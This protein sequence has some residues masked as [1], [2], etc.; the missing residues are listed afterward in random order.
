MIRLL[1]LA[2]YIPGKGQQYALQVLR[3]IRNQ[4]LAVELKFVGGDMGRAANKSYLRKLQAQARSLN[5]H[6][7]TEFAG[8]TGEVMQEMRDAHII[9]NFSASESFSMVCLEALASAKPLVATRCGG[10]QEIIRHQ[11]NGLLVANGDVHEMTSA[12]ADLVKNP[13]LRTKFSIN[14]QVDFQEKF[15]LQILAE[16]LAQIYQKAWD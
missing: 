4:N 2:N 15:N 13:S 12:V 1:Y 11:Y 14:S 6:D 9:L 3:N 5:V 10:P 7:I 8:P 16:Y